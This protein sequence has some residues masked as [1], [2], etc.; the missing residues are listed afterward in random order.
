[1]KP[2][3]YITFMKRCPKKLVTLDVGE[4]YED[5]DAKTGKLYGI[6]I[7]DYE[8]LTYDT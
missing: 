2:P 8:K 7:L 1:M 3:L 6:E 5:R 4:F